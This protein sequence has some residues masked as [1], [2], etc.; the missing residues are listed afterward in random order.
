VN[1]EA[2][3]RAPA[4]TPGITQCH[5]PGADVHGVSDLGSGPAVR[6]APALR[7][8]RL[9]GDEALFH[10][11]HDTEFVQALHAGDGGAL[12]RA[13]LGVGRRSAARLAQR[14]GSYRLDL[15]STVLER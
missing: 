9:A 3:E 4:G 15:D 6:D 12:L 7:D 14:A 5:R 13:A 8:A 2:G 11:R 1:W 10:R